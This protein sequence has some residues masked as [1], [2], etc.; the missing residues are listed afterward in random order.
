MMK[1]KKERKAKAPGQR[2][3]EKEKAAKGA[4]PSADKT[5]SGSTKKGKKEKSGV[6]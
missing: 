5:P 4:G 3:E 1:R 2:R 6:T